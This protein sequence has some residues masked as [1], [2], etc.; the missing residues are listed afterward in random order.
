M[1]SRISLGKKENISAE[2][3]DACK[4]NELTVTTNRLLAKHMREKSFFQ[5]PTKS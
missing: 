4:R 2:R 3:I 1:A 5:K